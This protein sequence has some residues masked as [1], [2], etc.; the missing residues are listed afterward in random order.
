MANP[1]LGMIEFEH[2]PFLR[3][4]RNKRLL[5]FCQLVQA[6]AVPLHSIL[7]SSLVRPRPP[8]KLGREGLFTAFAPDT[9]NPSYATECLKV[10]RENSQD[11][12]VL[13]SVQHLCTQVR[14]PV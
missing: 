6:L 12:S 5:F 1:P 7:L 3:L 9:G 11:C 14:T 4:Y 2:E 10:K 8:K 13:G